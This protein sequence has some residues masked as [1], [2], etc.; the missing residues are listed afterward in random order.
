MNPVDLDGAMQPGLYVGIPDDVYHG[1]TN[2]LSSSGARKLL[3]PSCPAIFRHEQLHGTEHKDYFDEGHALHRHVLG[4][5]A[6]IDVIDAPDWR[7]K[8]AK[9]AR[10]NAYAAGR[11][12]LLPADDA[13][14]RDM[15][16]A[17][18]DHPEAADLFADGDPEL[19]IWWD[20]PETGLRLR[21][22]PDWMTVRRG[23]RVLGDLKKTGKGVDPRSIAKT[24]ATHGYHQ[25]HPWYAEGVRAMELDDDP[26]FVFVFVSDDP[27]HLVTVCELNPADV[28]IGHQLN[29]HAID[30]WAKCV[31]TDTWPDYDRGGITRITLPAY[32]HYNAEEILTDV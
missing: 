6:E 20:D 7:T 25:Q 10:A 23:R 15:A 14:I 8:A 21:A 27:P 32:V 5:G 26:A 18:L 2:S 16:V 1:D 19:S 29:R 30:I 12:P 17:V 4:V 13:R 31:A 28:E 11:I 3:P 24:I 9:Q 22:R